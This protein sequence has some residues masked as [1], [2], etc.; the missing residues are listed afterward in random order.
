[1]TLTYEFIC[2]QI[3]LLLFYVLLLHIL[4][5]LSFLVTKYTDKHIASVIA[6]MWRPN[7][8]CVRK[9]YSWKYAEWNGFEQM[10]LYILNK[11][12]YWINMYCLCTFLG[13]P[14]ALLTTATDAS[15]LWLP[16]VSF[17]LP[18]LSWRTSPRA[19][20]CPKTC[21]DPVRCICVVQTITKMC[22]VNIHY[23]KNCKSAIWHHQKTVRITQEFTQLS[24]NISKF[25]IFLVLGLYTSNKGTTEHK[26]QQDNRRSHFA[27]A[28]HSHHP[29]QR[30][31]GPFCCCMTLFAANTLRCVARGRKTPQN[32][33]FPFGFRHLPEEDQTTVIGST[34]KK[35]V[36]IVRSVPE[37]S[38]WTDRQMN[39]QTNAQT[40]KD[41]DRQ[42]LL[43][44]ILH[45]HS[46][47][48]SNKENWLT[49]E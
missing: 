28:V 39:R 45:H 31:N 32:C 8:S 21:R 13:L 18:P 4:Y 22:V 1:M 29:R 34:H 15:R 3:H 47:G 11:T 35:L 44:T 41:T 37:I 19:L 25:Q 23:R 33:P 12:T 36:K 7:Q 6:K 16:P 2:T 17:P 49:V 10:Q 48:W 43:I 27:R 38:C 40:D 46:H 20:T 42:T 24:E 26:L 30:W 5:V 9:K 14:L